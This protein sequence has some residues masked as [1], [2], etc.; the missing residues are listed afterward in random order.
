V[1]TKDE[2]RR[3]AVNIAR[4]LSGVG[5]CRRGTNLAFCALQQ[6]TTMLT[7]EECW[8]QA[9][10]CAQLRTGADISTWQATKLAEIVRKWD[11]LAWEIERFRRG[12]PTPIVEGG[13]VITRLMRGANGTDFAAPLGSFGPP[14]GLKMPH[15]SRE[16]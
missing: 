9:D 12:I 6:G 15:P 3:I 2:A 14:D 1:L 16:R 10:E 4:C 7:P 11:A 13:D 5:A 8:A